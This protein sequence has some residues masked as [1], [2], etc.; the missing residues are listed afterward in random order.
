MQRGILSLL[1]LSAAILPTAGASALRCAAGT[2]EGTPGDLQARLTPITDGYIRQPCGADSDACFSSTGWIETGLHWRV[3]GSPDNE[4]AFLVFALDPHLAPGIESGY[5]HLYSAHDDNCS[6]Y[7]YRMRTIPASSVLR[8]GTPQA[9]AEHLGTYYAHGNQTENYIQEEN[10]PIEITIFLGQSVKWYSANVTAFMQAA[11]RSADFRNTSHV[12]FEI[13]AKSPSQCRAAINSSRSSAPPELELRYKCMTC[14]ANSFSSVASVD[15]SNCT[16]S[17]GYTGPN[18]G[19]CSACKAG[20]YK[21]KN[22]SSPCTLCAAGKFSLV[23]AQRRQ[24][25]CS[26]C[27]EVRHALTPDAGF[28]PPK[29][30]SAGA[31]RHHADTA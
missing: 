19:A 22:G 20:S 2:Y 16:C 29:F 8:T 25:M 5:L 3:S 10:Q 1:V 28:L 6:L 30:S 27:S 12:A 18:G 9:R 4:T 11:V 24:S 23:E 14:P 13:R 26:D 31:M 21:D 17:E 15:I 7:E